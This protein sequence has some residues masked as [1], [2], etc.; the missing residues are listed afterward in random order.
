MVFYRKTTIAVA[1][2]S[3][4]DLEQTAEEYLGILSPES[5][6]RPV[7]L[8]VSRMMDRLEEEL[9]IV[10]GVDDL[11]VGDE[12]YTDPERREIIVDTQ[13]YRA[14]LAGNGRARHTCV[15][16]VGHIPHIPQITSVIRDGGP[17]L[18]RRLDVEAPIY[19]CPEWQADG[20]AGAMLMPR[21]T[22][23][24]VFRAGGLQA[25]ANTFQVSRAAARTRVNVLSKLRLLP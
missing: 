12:G 3:R 18:A 13:A 19:C 22:T 5:L 1:P 17:Q 21:A 6:E 15:H 24:A 14:M 23:P 10:F 4:L 2:R 11:P 25:V 20:V 9:G 16:E 8:D 7:A